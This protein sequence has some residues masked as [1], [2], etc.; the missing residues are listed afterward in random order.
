MDWIIIDT[1][2]DLDQTARAVCQA[3][4]HVIVPTRPSVMDLESVAGTLALARQVGTPAS[5]LFNLVPSRSKEL[6]GAQ[7]ELSRRGCELMPTALTDR[8]AYRR[9]VALG[10]IASDFDDKAA[11]ELD[12][13]WGLMQGLVDP[14]KEVA[15]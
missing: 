13:V 11:R 15:A 8:V 10:K 5:V 3:A 9:A 12:Q 14:K 2:P 1:M 7:R 6:R 4:Q